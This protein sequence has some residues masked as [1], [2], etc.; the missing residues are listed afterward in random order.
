MSITKELISKARESHELLPD[1]ER[2]VLEE[3]SRVVRAFHRAI[4]IEHADLCILGVK[5]LSGDDSRF[6][7]LAS[8]KRPFGLSFDLGADSI[9]LHVI[10]RGRSGT[11]DA[12]GCRVDLLV[13]EGASKVLVYSSGPMLTSTDGVKLQGARALD[14]PGSGEWMDLHAQLEWRNSPGGFPVEKAPSMDEILRTALQLVVERLDVVSEGG[15]QTN[16]PP[17]NTATLEIYGHRFLLS[18]SPGLGCS[19]ETQWARP[20]EDDADRLA[21]LVIESQILAAYQAGALWRGGDFDPAL[22]ESY[23]ATMDAFVPI[24]ESLDDDPADV[25]THRTRI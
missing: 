10:P 6:P 23:R 24:I 19:I 12:Q 22:V 13:L 4:D 14:T 1:R 8:I 11:Q 2:G 15:A 16:A 18:G 3:Q 7:S 9:Q 5:G 20:F 21:H 25:A 17:N